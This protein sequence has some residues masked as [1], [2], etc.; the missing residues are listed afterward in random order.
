M[1]MENDHIIT[2]SLEHAE[3]YYHL[4]RAFEIAFAFLRE[5]ALAELPTGRHEIDGDN[6]FCIIGK[7][8]GRTRTEAK[9]EAHRKYI[10][11]QYVIAG[12]DEMGFRPTAD[13]K[14][15]DTS[16]VA[17]KDIEFFNDQ[18]NSWTPVPPGSFVIFFPQDAHAPLVSSGELHKV[19]LKIAVE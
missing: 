4:H 7:E 12:T 18:P 5:N 13:C 19:V 1:H 10:D 9:L 8:T 11:I 6:L 3:D 14:L 15:I 2:D 17:D 16:Y